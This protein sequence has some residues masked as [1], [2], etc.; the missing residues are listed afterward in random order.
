M[1]RIGSRRRRCVRLLVASSTVLL[2]LLAVPAVAGAAASPPPQGS[3][4]FVCAPFFASNRGDGVTKTISVDGRPLIDGD[5][6]A[7][8]AVVDVELR[9]DPSRFTSNGPVLV[10]DCVETDRNGL[11]APLNPWLELPELERSVVPLDPASVAAGRWVTSYR[12]PA[13]FGRRRICD[14][15]RVG[16]VTA[17]GPVVL[18]SDRICLLVTSGPAPV[19]PEFPVPAVA[20]GAGAVATAWGL[21]RLRRRA[22]PT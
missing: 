3:A 18:H 17:S 1:L 21:V 12:V 8:G 6:V 11:F 2:G 16:G 5:D 14:N 15:G 13:T 9:W 20:L 22:T 19:V 7:R 10:A 4:Q